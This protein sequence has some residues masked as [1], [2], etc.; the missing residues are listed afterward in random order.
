MLRVTAVTLHPQT[1]SNHGNEAEKRISHF[2]KLNCD[3][4]H[5]LFWLVNSAFFLEAS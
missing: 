5:F 2:F 4:G 3:S 1:C